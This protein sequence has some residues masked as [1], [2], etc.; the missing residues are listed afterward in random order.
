[1]TDPT[2]AF[3]QTFRID[4]DH[5]RVVL[6]DGRELAIV[7]MWNERGEPACDISTGGSLLVMLD[8]EEVVLLLGP[9]EIMH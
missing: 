5:R 4:L 6:A 1:M 2:A 3:E 9:P 7:A 8:D